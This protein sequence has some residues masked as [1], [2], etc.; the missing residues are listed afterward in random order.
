[1]ERFISTNAGPV[2]ISADDMIAGRHRDRIGAGARTLVP[3]YCSSAK[4]PPPVNRMTSSVEISV[5]S[6]DQPSPSLPQRPVIQLRRRR[7][8]VEKKL[9]V[10]LVRS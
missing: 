7:R 5:K 1:M 9:H 10:G 3:S 4:Q 2:G 6:Y 8:V